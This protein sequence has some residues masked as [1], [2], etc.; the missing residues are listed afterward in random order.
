MRKVLIQQLG[1][2][3]CHKKHTNKSQ[4][5]CPYIPNSLC[6]QQSE[7]GMQVHFISCQRLVFVLCVA[8]LISLFMYKN[9]LN[10]CNEEHSCDSLDQ[11]N[12]AVVFTAECYQTAGLCRQQSKTTVAQPFRQHWPLSVPITYTKCKSFIHTYVYNFFNIC[13]ANDG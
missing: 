5:E 11:S 9:F 6:A 1:S 8:V 7:L 3:D 12:S 4:M 13:R 2:Q 10:T